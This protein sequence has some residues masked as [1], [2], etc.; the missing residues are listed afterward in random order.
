MVLKADVDC[1]C[2]AFKSRAQFG[3]VLKITKLLPFL[4]V[5]V[6]YLTLLFLFQ[7]FFFFSFLKISSCLVARKIRSFRIS[8]RNFFCCY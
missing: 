2:E 3:M 4:T 8:A 7:P 1:L 5:D 6:S